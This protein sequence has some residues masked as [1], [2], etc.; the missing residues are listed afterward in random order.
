VN[1]G[2]SGATTA[3]VAALELPVA[4]DA[5]PALVTIWPGIND[6]RAGTTIDTFSEQLERVLAG[7]SDSTLVVVLNIPDLRAIPVF[8]T[9]SPDR[10]DARVQEWNS[11]IDTIA[12]RHAAIVVDLY[13]S[14]FELANHPEYVGAD[15]FHPSSAG[16]QRIADLVLEA[17]AAVDPDAFS[18]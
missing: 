5:A 18:S 3:D 6:L 7:L 16:H 13:G 11:V 8:A 10:L 9:S 1:L 14:A 2:I 12:R 15:G 17:L 4:S